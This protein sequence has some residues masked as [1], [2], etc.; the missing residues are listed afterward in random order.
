LHAQSIREI[1]SEPEDQIKK[2]MNWR[3]HYE[4][5]KTVQYSN[6]LSFVQHFTASLKVKKGGNGHQ[7]GQG[8]GFVSGFGQHGGRRGLFGKRN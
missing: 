8:D 1:L 6:E 3:D 2:S 4:Q 5:F 7:G